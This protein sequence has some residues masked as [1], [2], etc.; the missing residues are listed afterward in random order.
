MG[1]FRLIPAEETGQKVAMADINFTFYGSANRPRQAYPFSQGFD[2]M[3]SENYLIESGKQVFV[4]TKVFVNLPSGFFASTHGPSNLNSRAVVRGSVFD[5]SYDGTVK[6]LIQNSGE[7]DLAIMAG[8]NVAVLIIEPIN[9]PAVTFT[10][11]SFQIFILFLTNS[12]SRN[13]LFVE[14]SEIFLC[15]IIRQ[16]V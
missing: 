12:R 8:D 2:L 3:A 7:T 10:Q 13:I 9:V 5:S 4:E 16:I 6:I 11:V 14:A 1:K 15:R